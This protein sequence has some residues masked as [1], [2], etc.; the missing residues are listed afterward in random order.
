MQDVVY[1]VGL[2]ATIVILISATVSDIRTREIDDRHWI[3]LGIIGTAVQ[4]IYACNSPTYM[5]AGVI[6]DILLILYMFWNKTN[7]IYGAAV[8]VVAGIVAL[9][10]WLNDTSNL[11]AC[12]NVVTV[13]MFLSLLSMYCLGLIRGGADVKAL[14][15]IAIAFPT[16]IT[17]YGLPLLWDT[18][19]PISFLFNP[20]IITLFIALIVSMLYSI[21]TI[22]LNIKNGDWHRSMFSAYWMPIED[23]RKSFV[24]PVID[25]NGN[26]IFRTESYDESDKI[27][28]RLENAGYNRVLVTPMIPFMLPITIGF[29]FTIVLGNPISA[30]L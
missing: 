17:S 18:A 26:K 24:W 15:C 11:I 16:Y 29:I 14:M 10:P 22:I 23:A 6:I 3:I 4:A 30:I 25:A 21:Y 12:R 9:L 2:I 20:I 19:P 7:G 28:N 1:L 8:L 13:V 27:Y 5:I